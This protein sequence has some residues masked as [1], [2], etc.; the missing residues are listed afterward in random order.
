MLIVRHEPNL[1]DTTDI[2]DRLE[3]ASYKRKQKWMAKPKKVCQRSDLRPNQTLRAKQPMAQR[4]QQYNGQFK[5]ASLEEV[6][7]LREQLS[8]ETGRTIGVPR[9]TKHPAWH[10][11]H[12]LAFENKLVAL[13]NQYSA[14][15]KNPHPCSSNRLN[16][17]IYKP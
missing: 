5:I 17:A 2:A 14:Q 6:L 8:R 16:W 3:F 13:L 10:A 9:K 15:S 1:K 7:Q 11:E 12:G 4:N